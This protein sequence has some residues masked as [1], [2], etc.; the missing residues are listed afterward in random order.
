MLRL[1]SVLFVLTGLS[2]EAHLRVFVSLSLPENT[3]KHLYKDT[4]KVGGTLVIR[5][6]PKNSFM[7]MAKVFQ[8]LE[9]EAQMD[10][11]AFTQEDIKVVPTFILEE[12][13]KKDKISGHLSLFYVLELFSKE[14]DVTFHAKSLLEKLN[15]PSKEKLL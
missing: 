5:G 4:Q 9:I 7:E 3:L 14:G 11:E 2:C 1:L 6:L 15:S 8:R 13:V 12:G 10:P